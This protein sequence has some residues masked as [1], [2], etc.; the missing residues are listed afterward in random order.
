VTPLSS[1][2]MGDK[3]LAVFAMAFIALGVILLIIG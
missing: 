1:W 2:S 3:I